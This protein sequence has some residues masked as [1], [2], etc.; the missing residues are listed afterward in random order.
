M[1]LTKPKDMVS[2]KVAQRRLS[3]NVASERGFTLVEVT[4]IL[5]VLVILSTIT[6]PAMPA[7][8]GVAMMVKKIK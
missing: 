5:L 1:A 7:I 2:T 6:L 4:I 8:A 3:P